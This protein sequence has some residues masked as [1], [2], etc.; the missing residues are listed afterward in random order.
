MSGS[1]DLDTSTTLS[2][3]LRSLSVVEMSGSKK[4]WLQSYSQPLF[5]GHRFAQTAK[6]S[7]NIRERITNTE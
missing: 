3:Q 2:E 5:T 4:G 1:L 7:D 6:L